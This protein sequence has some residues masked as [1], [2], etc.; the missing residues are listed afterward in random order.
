[1]ASYIIN[2]NEF[3]DNPLPETKIY[4]KI[5][6]ARAH[7]DSMVILYACVLFYSTASRATQQ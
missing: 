4:I 1:M 2:F 3:G 5:T 7:A 6:L